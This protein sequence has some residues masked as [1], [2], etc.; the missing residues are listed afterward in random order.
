ML[1]QGTSWTGKPR[2]TEAFSLRADRARRT[3]RPL[4]GRAGQRM[5][6]AVAR[7][8][9]RFSRQRAR[10]VD[11]R[12][13]IRPGR[14]ADAPARWP[15]GST[16]ARDAAGPTLVMLAHPR[17]DCTRASL[18]EL[19]ELLARAPQRPRTF[20]VFIRARRRCERRGSR[21]AP[22]DQAT[23][24]PGVTVIRDDNGDEARPLRRLDLG[25][26][27]AVRRGTASSCIP[28]ASPAPAASPATTSDA[29]RFSNCSTAHTRPA[30]P[31]RSSAALSSP[32][33]SVTEGQSESPMVPELAGVR[34]DVLGASGSES[35]D[36]DERM[37]SFTRISRRSTSGPIGCSPI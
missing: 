31:L 33:R 35:L 5:L 14:R 18:G 24:I 23:R 34:P 29:P 1:Q 26:D 8:V 4:V 7:R 9:V 16:L 32:G 15:A 6:W 22:G 2:G 25:P 10:V 21:P 36:C 17:C 11:G 19:A 20:V 3:L 37:R 30:R 12:T 28:V 27:P 13:T